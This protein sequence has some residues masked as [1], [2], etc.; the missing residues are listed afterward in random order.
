MANPVVFF[1]VSIGGVEQGRIKVE[2]FAHRLPRTCENFRQLCT[3][4][5]RVDGVPMGYKHSRFHRI[6]KDFVI[7]GGDFLNNGGVFSIY[8]GVFDDEAFVESHSRP[9]LL[10]MANSGPNTN[11]CEFF[12]TCAPCEFLDRKHVVFGQVVEGMLTVRK[13]ENTP[14][15]D[16]KPRL[17]VVITEC[18][19]M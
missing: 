9:G 17:D 5:T 4:E 8:G 7:H 6:V 15:V 10:S 14:T 18:G 16:G 1:D 19:E 12:I 13:I 11:G 2:L 3:G